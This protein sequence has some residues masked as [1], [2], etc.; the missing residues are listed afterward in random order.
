VR[1]YLNLEKG[2]VEILLRLLGEAAEARLLNPSER[3]IEMILQEALDNI[4]KGI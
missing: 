3:Y 2:H 4:D 1:S